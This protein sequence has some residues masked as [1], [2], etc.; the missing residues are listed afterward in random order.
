MRLSAVLTLGGCPPTGVKRAG[1]G[2]DHP[3]YWVGFR[4]ELAGP[5]GGATQ[6]AERTAS[7]FS[8]R[9]W[10]QNSSQSS[11]RIKDGQDQVTSGFLGERPQPPTRREGTAAAPSDASI[12]AP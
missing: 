9:S 5:L 11:D 2:R 7:T 12:L 4:K 8:G 10:E 1:T 3:A 6:E